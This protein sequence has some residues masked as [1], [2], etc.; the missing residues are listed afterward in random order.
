M[1]AHLVYPTAALVIAMQLGFQIALRRSEIETLPLD[2]AGVLWLLVSF[3]PVL[4]LCQ[5]LQIALHRR[6]VA[7][8]ASHCLLL[9]LHAL[10]LSFRRFTHAPLDYGLLRDNF[11]ELFY[12]ETLALVFG[13]VRG[14]IV[15]GVVLAL[16]GLVLLELRLRLFSR[17]GRPS[18]PRLRVA[19]ALAAFALA[20]IL[21]PYSHDELVSF[22]RSVHAYYA[23]PPES[24]DTQHLRALGLDPGARYPYLRREPAARLPARPR[25]VFLVAVESFNARFVGARTADGREITPVVNTLARRGLFAPRFY[26]NSI[27]TARGHVAILCSVLPSIRRKILVSYPHLRLRCLPELLRAHGY[28]TLFFTGQEDLSFDNMGPAAKRLGFELVQP[29]DRR[30]APEIGAEER[31]GWGV[32][33]DRLFERALAHLDRLEREAPGRPSFLFLPTISN[34]A[35]FDNVPQRLRYLHA[36]PR[37]GE[38]A[39]VNSIHLTDRYLGALLDGIAR[40]PYLR[41]AIV[42]I[43][44]DHSFAI[45]EHGTYHNE[46]GSYEESFRTPLVILAPG[47]LAPQLVPGRRSQIDLAPTILELLG[48]PA[49]EHH[50]LGRSLLGPPRLPG[51]SRDLPVLLSQ[52]YDGQHLCVIEGDVKYV[53]QTRTGRERLH[54]L[55]RDPTESKNLA[56]EPAWRRALE[57]GRRGLALFLFNQRLIEENRFWPPAR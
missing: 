34:H 51:G 18:R 33:D 26:G 38:E 41:E 19:L 52:P 31:W 27:Q 11:R 44:G 4:A 54:D 9:A 21:P 35:W 16:S 17:W 40:R 48:L 56:A 28:R 57:Q 25:T 7:L 55:A 22:L 8:C 53:R 42:V 1:L 30:F 3:V 50:F 23:P 37:N 6:R 5:L 49:G 36:R 43:T 12:P 32:Q 47:R 20:S 2:A 46:V 10:L 29:M 39:Y 45:G 24:L 13:G 15:V 14:L